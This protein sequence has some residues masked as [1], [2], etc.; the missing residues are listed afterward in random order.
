MAC[1]ETPNYQNWVVDLQ[2]VSVG[3]CCCTAWQE[4]AEILNIA[5]EHAAQGQG[6]GRALLRS[7]I[8]LLPGSVQRVLLEVR[9][10]NLPAIGLYQSM[11]FVLI[12]ERKNYYQHGSGIVED[13]LIYQLTR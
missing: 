8:E 12:G 2:D 5:I 7:S 13:A 10:S 1:L 9:R 11:G 6:V 3:F 4:D